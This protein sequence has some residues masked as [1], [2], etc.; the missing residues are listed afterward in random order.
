MTY[1]PIQA[2]NTVSEGLSHLITQFQNQPQFAIYLGAF[3]NRL[4]RLED[5]VWQVVRLRAIG[6]DASPS[7]TGVQLDTLGTII[8]RARAGL[9]DSDY[10]TF[11]LPAQIL[12]NLSSGIPDDF[13]ALIALATPVG[14]LATYGESYPHCVIITLT[15]TL[16]NGVPI[17]FANLLLLRAGGVRL[18]L[19]WTASPVASTFTFAP[20]GADVPG[21]TSQGFGH[22]GSS[23]YGGVMSAALG[24]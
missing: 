9:S 11:G 23:I 2:T 16:A 21:P 6:T 12:I 17:L 8:G 20:A 3:L 13:L 4:Q 14:T 10:R 5:A 7:A 24:A 1:A 22:A 15:T 18:I 19:V